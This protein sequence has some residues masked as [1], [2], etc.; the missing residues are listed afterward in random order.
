M[1]AYKQDEFGFTGLMWA[2][3]LIVVLQDEF[4]AQ[5]TTN[6]VKKNYI[7]DFDLIFLAVEEWIDFSCSP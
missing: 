4:D 1:W 7:I 2:Y 6:F 3:K 5:P